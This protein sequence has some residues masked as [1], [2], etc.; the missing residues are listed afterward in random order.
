MLTQKIVGRRSTKK[1]DKGERVAGDKWLDGS[2]DKYAKDADIDF[3]EALAEL[4]QVIANK[5][6]ERSDMAKSAQA[7][8]DQTQQDNNDVDEMMK[9]L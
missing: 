4:Q 5:V 7:A 9:A 2:L 6:R 8:G 3:D 1:N